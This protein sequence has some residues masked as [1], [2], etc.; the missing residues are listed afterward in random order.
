MSKRTVEVAL[1]VKPDRVG[2]IDDRQFAARQQAT[3][4]FKTQSQQP[5]VRCHADGPFELLEEREPAQPAK[6]GEVIQGNALIDVT[7]TIVPEA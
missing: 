3:G 4:L 2:D 1:I 5:C 6:T 7:E